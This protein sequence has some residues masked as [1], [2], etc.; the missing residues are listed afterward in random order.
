MA[1]VTTPAE[2][3]LLRAG[4]ILAE[5]LGYTIAAVEDVLTGGDGLTPEQFE[6]ARQG[7][8]AWR[9]LRKLAEA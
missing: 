3:E 9:R 8:L 7:I 5:M 2:A 4:D 6:G 1:R